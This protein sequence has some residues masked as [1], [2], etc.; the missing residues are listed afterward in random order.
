MKSGRNGKDSG[1]G[2]DSNMGNSYVTLGKSPTFSAAG[3]EG[4]TSVS[5]TINS[6]DRSPLGAWSTYKCECEDYG[7]KL[8]CGW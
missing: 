2:I 7:M 5:S 8:Q 3:G 6:G 1:L 4:G